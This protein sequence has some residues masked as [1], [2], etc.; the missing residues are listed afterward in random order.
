MATEARHAGS[1]HNVASLL[2]PNP[3]Y[4]GQ[5]GIVAIDSLD[6]ASALSPNV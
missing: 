3:E 2:P 4:N 6:R 5:V 1:P